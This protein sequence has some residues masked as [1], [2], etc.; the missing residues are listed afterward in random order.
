MTIFVQGIWALASNLFRKTMWFSHP[1][2]R[3]LQ[4]G[5]GHCPCQKATGYFFMHHHFWVLWETRWSRN[6]PK[7]LG[8][9]ASNPVNMV[10]ANGNLPP[11]SEDFERIKEVSAQAIESV[12][13][14]DTDRA[15]VIKGRKEFSSA[16]QRLQ[17]P[18]ICRK[19]GHRE[20]G[21]DWNAM[22]PPSTFDQVWVSVISSSKPTPLPLFNVSTPY[23]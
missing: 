20:G 19:R 15:V 3:G 12:S 21:H 10:E 6:P 18:Y 1:I 5:D 22:Y 16:S 14:A 23:F 17:E 2:G 7:A 13:R 8:Q 11:A 9:G 4:E